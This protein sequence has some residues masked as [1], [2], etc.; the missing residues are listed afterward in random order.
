MNLFLVKFSAA[1]GFKCV[2]NI[3]KLILTFAFESKIGQNN[4]EKL[5]TPD[6]GDILLSNAG[7]I[8]G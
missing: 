2:G 4:P 5:I 3:R 6:F 7:W 1:F 8:H